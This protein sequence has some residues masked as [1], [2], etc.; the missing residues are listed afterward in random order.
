MS[1]LTEADKAEVLSTLTKITEEDKDKY[2]DM[3][4]MIFIMS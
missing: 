4:I 1:E 3:F 2:H